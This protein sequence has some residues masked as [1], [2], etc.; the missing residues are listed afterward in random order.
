MNEAH[1]VKQF[2]EESGTTVP[3]SPSP[4]TRDEVKFICKM[5]LDEVMELVATVETPVYAKNMLVTLI[6]SSNDIPKIEYDSTES[7]RIAQIADQADAFVDIQYYMLNCACK[8]G[9]NLSSVFTLV[10]AANMAKRDP[11][12]GLFKKREDGKIMKPTGWQPPNVVAEI[13]RQCN[14]GAWDTD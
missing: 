14:E 13:E 6:E 12:T 8:K 2:T 9:I 4:L 10:H 3:P 11:E 7:G 5:I 1:A